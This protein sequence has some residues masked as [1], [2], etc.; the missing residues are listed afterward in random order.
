MASGAPHADNV[1]PCL[2]GGGR[3]I[4]SYDPLHVVPVP[5]ADSLVWTI[6]HPHMTIRTEDARRILP[7]TIPLSVAVRQW[8]NVGGLILGLIT[9]EAGLLGMSTEDAVVEPVRAKL[10]PGFQEVKNSALKAGALGCS[11]SGSGPSM[12]AI[13]TSMAKARSIG[14]EMAKSFLS[15]ANLTCD[16]YV[17]R[18]NRKGAR[19]LKASVE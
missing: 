11:I 8:G 9:G 18:L 1:G 10:I 6:V 19:I 12:F 5:V 7:A 14:A 3:L 4:R 15:A 2:L 13:T 16:I 17:S